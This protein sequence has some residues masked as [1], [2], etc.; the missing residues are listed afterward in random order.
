MLTK[1]P[2]LLTISLSRFDM[3]YNTWQRFK[4]NDRFEY[5][6]ELDLKEFVS[7]DL[8]KDESYNYELKSIII[9]RGGAFGGH[10]FAYIKDDLKE[11][12]WDL[13]LPKE[14]EKEPKKIEKTKF[15]PKD[16]VTDE[17]LKKMK[18]SG[19]IDQLPEHKKDEKEEDEEEKK[20]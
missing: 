12:V 2:P 16:H 6:L 1:V 13:E 8:P 15:N 19:A 3:D 5:P 17:Q 14:F 20:K 10:Y 11:G 7:P 18:E 9:H 4:L